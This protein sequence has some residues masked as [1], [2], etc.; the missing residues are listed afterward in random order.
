MVVEVNNDGSAM[1]VIQD[2][3]YYIHTCKYKHHSNIDKSQSP[4]LLEDMVSNIKDSRVFLFFLA[5]S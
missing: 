1:R 3:V 2:E 5:D 4:L